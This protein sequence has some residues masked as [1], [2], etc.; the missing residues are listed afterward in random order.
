[1]QNPRK[2]LIQKSELLPLLAQCRP[3]HLL[4]VGAG[5]IGAMIGDIKNV[6]GQP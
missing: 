6:L 2:T 1:M 4:T 3:R 5:D